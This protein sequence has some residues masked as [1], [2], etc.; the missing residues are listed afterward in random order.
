MIWIA[1]LLKKRPS[2]PM[3]SVFPATPPVALKMDW[4]KFA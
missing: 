3:V 2:P 1:R 4:T